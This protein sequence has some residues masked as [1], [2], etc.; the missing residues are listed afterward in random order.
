[1]SRQHMHC[2]VHGLAVLLFVSMSLGF[3]STLRFTYM[4]LGGGSDV[5]PEAR[6]AQTRLLMLIEVDTEGQTYLRP[7]RLKHLGF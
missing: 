6:A 7:E 4:H 5:V 3:P 1:M 2:C